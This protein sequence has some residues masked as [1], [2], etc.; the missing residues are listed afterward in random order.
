MAPISLAL[1][2]NPSNPHP[3]HPN[4]SNPNP[5]PHPDARVQAGGCSAGAHGARDHH[6]APALCGQGHAA[7][8]AGG[9]ALSPG[10][11]RVGAQTAWHSVRAVRQ[12]N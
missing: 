4:P 1:D 3:S 8:P 9:C 7:V 12:R 11:A 10:V 5:H 2:P 6:D